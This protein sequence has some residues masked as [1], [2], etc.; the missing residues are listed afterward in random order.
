MKALLRRP[1]VIRLGSFLFSSYLKLVYATHSWTREGLEHARGVWADSST[2]AILLLWHQGIPL[3]P[4]AW[5]RREGGQDMR[6]LISKSAD[7][8]FITQVMVDLGFPAIRGSRQ[9]AN[10]VGDK[11]GAAALRD[12]VKW[13]KDG[14]AVAITPDGPKGPARIMGEGPATA[15]RLTGVPVLLVGLACRN[16]VRIKSWDRTILPLPFGKA[17]MVYHPVLR[18]GRDD[19]LATLARDWTDKLNAVTDRAEAIVR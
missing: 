9:R 8:E 13:V 7:G 19:D 15:A 10:S 3:S 2:G 14:N 4:N 17:A 16:C 18:A 5:P 6:A 1:A 12:M 11:G